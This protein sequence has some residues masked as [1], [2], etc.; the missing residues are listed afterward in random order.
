MRSG[1][2]AL[3]AAAVWLVQ[4]SRADSATPCT[5]ASRTCVVA[6]ATSYLDALSSHDASKVRLDP[7]VLRD[8]NGIISARGAT[9]LRHT[10]ATSPLLKL[11]K[12]VHDIQWIVEGDKADAL[13]LIETRAVP[14][15]PQHAA[16][17]H[18]FERFTVHDGLIA[19]I[20]V[21]EC[22]A[23]ALR[24]DGAQA[25]SRDADITDLCMRAGPKG[26]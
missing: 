23:G 8:E 26:L 7:D 2:V 20:D 13:Y 22:F 10:L 11:I 15:I 19:R 18:V 21:I 6:A 17:A 3:L 25:E 1:V 4:P 14:G 5:D 16:T 24:P 9:Q 12:R